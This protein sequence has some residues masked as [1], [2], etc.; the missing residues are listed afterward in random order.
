MNDVAPELLE[1][2][3]KIYLEKKDGNAVLAAI[4]KAIEKGEIK[5]EDAYRAA[6]E[7]G[8]ILGDAYGAV[9]NIDALP[10]GKMYYNIAQRVVGPTM[11]QA[12][13]DVADI[14]EETQ[15]VLNNNA[16]LG[17]KAIR[18]ELNQ[19]RIKGIIDRLS[20]TESFEEIAWLLKAPIQTFCQ[21]VVDDAVKI[22]DPREE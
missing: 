11:E 6:R 12:Y 19:D 1:K 21:S 20:S 18:P 10:D 16:G 8:Q 17:L 7:I 2:I 22:I 13:S 9:L 14:A 5:Y 15:N 4:A 3:I